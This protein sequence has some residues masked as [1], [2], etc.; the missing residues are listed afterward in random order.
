[1]QNTLDALAKASFDCPEAQE[2]SEYI[3]LTL[4]ENPPAKAAEPYV[5]YIVSVPYLT[6]II[7]KNANER[8]LIH[9]AQPVL[10]AIHSYFFE[11]DDII[12]DKEGVIGLLDDTYM[13]YRFI[14][15]LNASLAQADQAPLTNTNFKKAMKRMS[16]RLGPENVA[17][18]EQ[19]IESTLS[20]KL[21][22][23]DIAVGA[24]VLL[25]GLALLGGMSSGRNNH[26][27]R[28]GDAFERAIDG[29][30]M[31]GSV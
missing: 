22:G 1:M 20:T 10:T 7:W 28:W 29:G 4:L 26:I 17:L 8:S 11:S 27:D 19:H 3:E 14:E 13:V 31:D 23:F 9:Q 15:Q 12:S 25:G 6:Q 24:T 2:I 30:L 21:T 16:E 5:G 18:I